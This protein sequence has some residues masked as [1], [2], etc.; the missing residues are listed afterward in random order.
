MMGERY[1]ID[2]PDSFGPYEDTGTS[3]R[4]VATFESREEAIAWAVATYGADEE[5]RICVVSALPEEDDQA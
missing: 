5:G 1:S 3:W 4:E 2:L